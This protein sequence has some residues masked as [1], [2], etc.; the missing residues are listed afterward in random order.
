[1]SEI[2]QKFSEYAEIVQE[3]EAIY[4]EIPELYRLEKR[5]EEV[6][7]EIQ[8]WAK[9]NNAEASAA[10]WEVKLS[11]RPNLDTKALLVAHPE[12]KIYQ[13]MTVVA[14]VKRAK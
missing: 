5:A 8:D 14:S 9:A 12:M 6:K 7:K 2:E 4:A 10:G 11:E 1:M 3:L 13:S